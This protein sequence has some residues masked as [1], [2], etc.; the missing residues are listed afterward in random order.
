MKQDKELV[1]FILDSIKQAVSND[2]C[3]INQNHIENLSKMLNDI[4]VPF[5]ALK[6]IDENKK[7]DSA[8][9]SFLCRHGILGKR[10][11]LFS[12]GKFIKAL[13]KR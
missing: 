1:L 6:N 3:T 5:S 13:K 7:S 12:L 4:D 10:V 9:R 8:L 11:V 2:E